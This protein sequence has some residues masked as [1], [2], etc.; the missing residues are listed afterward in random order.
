MPPADLP[1][2]L[3]PK[4]AQ[5]LV[6]RV[7]TNFQKLVAEIKEKVYWEYEEIDLSPS[8]G[9]TVDEGQTFIKILYG[10]NYTVRMQVHIPYVIIPGIHWVTVGRDGRQ[11]WRP[12]YQYDDAAAYV[13]SI[14]ILLD[15]ESCRL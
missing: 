8:L 3:D 1:Y 2:Y 4:Y 9:K 6:T 14:E 5:E 10:P 7:P 12:N 13:E 15:S 11:E